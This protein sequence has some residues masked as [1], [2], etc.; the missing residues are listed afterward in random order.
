MEKRSVQIRTPIKTTFAVTSPEYL[1]TQVRVFL[2][3][4]SIPGSIQRGMPGKWE[5]GGEGERGRTTRDIVD[6]VGE[7][8]ANYLKNFSNL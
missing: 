4:N 1:V 6:M 3:D 2:K 7:I 5:R 8:S